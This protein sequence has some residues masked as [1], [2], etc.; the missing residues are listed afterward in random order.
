MMLALSPAVIGPAAVI[1]SAV[2]G[3]AAVCLAAAI[4]L[5][6]LRFAL[7]VIVKGTIALGEFSRGHNVINGHEEQ[8]KARRP[9]KPAMPADLEAGQPADLE[10]GQPAEPGGRPARH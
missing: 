3:T 4:C 5:R 8:G 2:I 10:A 1:G 9:G 7:V 6:R